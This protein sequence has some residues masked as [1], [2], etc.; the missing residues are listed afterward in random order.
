[1]N[2]MVKYFLVLVALLLGLQFWLVNFGEN[3]VTNRT[4]DIFKDD[5]VYLGSYLG[6]LKEGVYKTDVGDD[7]EYFRF[8]AAHGVGKFWSGDTYRRVYVGEWKDGY[9]DGQGKYTEYDTDRMLLGWQMLGPTVQCDGQFRKGIF[10]SGRQ[11]GGSCPSDPD[12]TRLIKWRNVFNT[13]EHQ[14]YENTGKE[15]ANSA[16]HNR[17]MIFSLNYT[18]R[19]LKSPCFGSTCEF[20]EKIAERI[21]ANLDSGKNRKQSYVF[22]LFKDQQP[23]DETKRRSKLVVEPLLVGP[24]KDEQECQTYKNMADENSYATKRCIWQG[25]LKKKESQ[26]HFFGSP[27]SRYKEGLRFF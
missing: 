21:G 18:I 12:G 16:R 25:E 5:V 13:D 2:K 14:T 24:F 26:Y 3:S 9:A 4:K 15:A 20:F 11:K 7:E 6:Q 10:V 27:T 8:Y 1:M 23:L 22:V 19:L 17:D